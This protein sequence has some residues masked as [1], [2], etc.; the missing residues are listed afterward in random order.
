MPR[1]NHTSYHLSISSSRSRCSKALA[2]SAA[3]VSADITTQVAISPMSSSS[4]S[5]PMYSKTSPRSPAL[6]VRCAFPGHVSKPLSSRALKFC[7]LLHSETN[8]TGHTSEN[9]PPTLPS[10]PI[11]NIRSDSTRASMLS[12]SDFSLER[13]KLRNGGKPE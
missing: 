9:S 12:S 3:R 6:A 1:N 4:P 2:R 5:N 7:S 13:L 8:P 10:Q 11:L